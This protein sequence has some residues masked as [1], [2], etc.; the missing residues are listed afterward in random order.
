[1]IGDG[2]GATGN[3]VVALVAGV[4]GLVV[5]VVVVDV[6][7]SVVQPDAPNTNPTP[8]HVASR[9]RTVP[10]DATP[11]TTSVYYDLRALQCRHA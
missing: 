3:D 4:T 7:T 1:L 6:S 2:S 5:A 11:F 8:I 9:R 10:R